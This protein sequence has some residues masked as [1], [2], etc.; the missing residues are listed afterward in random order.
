MNLQ[1]A[2]VSGFGATVILTSVGAAAQGLGLTRM[3][4]PF[5]LGTMVTADRDRAPLYGT[6]VHFV[7]GWIFAFL[8]IALFDQ[9]H[10]AQW[11]IGGAFGLVHALF[12]LLLGLPVLPDLHPRMAS[13]RHGPTP[14]RLLQPP[15]F[16]GLHYGVRTPLVIVVAHV[17]Y[18]IV[19]G[20][21]Y[22][23]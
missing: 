7:N 21:L 18:G 12:V 6:A 11:W 19:L 14:T 22:R 9:L 1:G 20:A 13:E 15:G 3:D 17:S 8:Y 16:L 4:L 5:I 23:V 10:A 2:L